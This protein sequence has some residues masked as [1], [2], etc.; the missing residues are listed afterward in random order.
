MHFYSS[1]EKPKRAIHIKRDIFS[2]LE[3]IDP[4]PLSFGDTLPPHSHNRAVLQF[5]KKSH[6]VECFDFSDCWYLYALN[7]LDRFISGRVN[8]EPDQTIEILMTELDPQVMEI[9]N[10]ANSSSGRDATKVHFEYS[11]SDLN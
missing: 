4:F 11:K 5:S 1:L 7:P 8:L 6:Y 3:T 2:I 9:F 10:K